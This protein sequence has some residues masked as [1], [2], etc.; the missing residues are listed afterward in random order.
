MDP[1]TAPRPSPYNPTLTF[2]ESALLC[3][4]SVAAHERL[5]FQEDDYT[6]NGDVDAS[7]EKF[8]ALLQFVVGQ[9][10]TTSFKR[11]AGDAKAL[12]QT[13]RWLS[14]RLKGL[15]P[16]WLYIG[17][18]KWDLVLLEPAKALQPGERDVEAGT[19]MRHWRTRVTIEGGNI[20]DYSTWSIDLI[21]ANETPKAEDLSEDLAGRRSSSCETM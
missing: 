20:P 13:R 21:R 9:N 18:G 15:K 2:A 3:A 6:S 7:L 14:G 17:R 8:E 4:V 12:Y 19:E 16:D 11:R 1:P 10:P 5:A